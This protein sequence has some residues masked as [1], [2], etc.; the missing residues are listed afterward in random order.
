MSGLD[1]DVVAW[2]AAV[3]GAGGTVSDAR[4]A[5]LNTMV[6]GLKNDGVWSKLDRLWIF[7]AEN[8]TSALR[9]F[10]ARSAATLTGAPTFTAD[11]GYV[12]QDAT[13][14]TIYIDSQYNPTT[15]ATTFASN[16]CHISAW[17]R[18]NTAS[19]N[20]G[21][22]NGLADN[23]G[24]NATGITVTFTDGNVY[25]RINDAT[26]SG[27]QG[28]PGTR[29]GHWVVNRSGASAT[30]VY[31]S[32]ALFSSPNATSGSFPNS[33]II[34]LANVLVGNAF[35][36]GTPNQVSATSMGGSLTSTDATNFY[37]RLQTYMT[38]VGA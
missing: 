7:A 31:Q 3:V 13:N 32:G 24:N 18:T 20:G 33:T 29:I 34:I 19:V 1:V 30:Q 9:D 23:A 4:K 36:H 22:L 15:D 25:G 2:A 35:F 5:L 11:R 16:S 8:S 38:A 37:N 17:S 6:A 26:A 10:V 14:P 12:G 27:S 21:S 28:V